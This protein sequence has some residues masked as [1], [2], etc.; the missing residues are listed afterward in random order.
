MHVAT[1]P[2]E[3]IKG[4]KMALRR[5]LFIYLYHIYLD[6][7]FFTTHLTV[8]THIDNKKTLSYIVYLIADAH[9]IAFYLF[10]WGGGEGGGGYGVKMDQL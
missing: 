6:L 8:I 5:N 9:Y 3:H 4:T 1:Y 7:S 10:F 2:I